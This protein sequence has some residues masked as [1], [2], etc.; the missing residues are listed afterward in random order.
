[1]SSFLDRQIPAP[2]R[3]GRWCLVVLATA[4]MSILSDVASAATPPGKASLERFPDDAALIVAWPGGGRG[5]D[6]EPRLVALDSW[7]GFVFDVVDGTMIPVESSWTSACRIADQLVPERGRR[8]HACDSDGRRWV[9]VVRWKDPVAIERG[10]RRL[11]TQAMGRGRFRLPVAGIEVAVREDWLVLGPQDSP[12]IEAALS[13]FASDPELL[14]GVDADAEA[15]IEV[16]I[17]HASPVSGSSRMRVMPETARR[18][19]IDL[20][21]DYGASPLPIRPATRLP[22]GDLEVLQGRFAMVVQESGVGLLDARLVEVATEHPEAIPPAL[23]RRAFAPGRVVVV[24]GETV[25]V[26]GMGLVEIPVVAVAVPL[27]EVAVEEA[28]P[29]NLDE[30][31]STIDEWLEAGTSSIRASWDPD[32]EGG[33]SRTRQGGIRH[34]SLGPGFLEA[35]G[36][37]PMAAIGR[38]AWV[39][40][41]DPMDPRGWLVVGSSIGLVRRV[42]DRLDDQWDRIANRDSEGSPVSMHAVAIPGRI[43]DQVGDLARI[44]R[45]GEDKEASTDAGLLEKLADLLSGFDRIDWISRVQEED[46]IQARIRVRRSGASGDDLPEADPDDSLGQRPAPK[47]SP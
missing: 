26:P 1:M 14:D 31:A 28:E 33:V 2:R 47:E 32:F 40:R 18:A 37:H 9:Q 46:R 5:V 44:R 27:R 6:R 10:L 36:G 8:W 42:A 3:H 16:V 41:F 25:D 4:W 12:W 19:T 21:G 17:R 43:V 34:L 13:G 39:S 23:I 15:S 22:A 45:N 7:A 20:E 11:G 24:D 35:T 30:L 29:R 38:L